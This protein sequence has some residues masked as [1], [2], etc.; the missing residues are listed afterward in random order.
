[1]AKHSRERFQ[2]V[3]TQIE[4][5]APAPAVILVTSA[6]ADDGSTIAAIGL[7]DCL[8]AA[9]HRVALLTSSLESAERDGA[10][11]RFVLHSLT[12]KLGVGSRLSEAVAALAEEA[13]REYD[14]TIIDGAPVPES[15]VSMSFASSVEAVLLSI[16]LGRSRC[17]EDELMMQALVRAEARVL[18]VVGVVCASEASIRELNALG[19][20]DLARDNRKLR[21]STLAEK[22]VFDCYGPVIGPPGCA[23]E[24]MMSDPRHRAISHLA[25]SARSRGC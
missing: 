10:R 21:R 2:I 3:R 7:A 12:D 14:Y 23:P 19:R 9:G 5:H 1:M 17:A 11:P 6:N 25:S 4:F 18:G 13:R 22:V 16:R 8:A 20:E 15:A 24:F